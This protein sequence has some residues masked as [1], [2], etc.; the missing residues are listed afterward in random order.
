[1]AQADA[2]IDRRA[3][4]QLAQETLLSQWRTY[5]AQRVIYPERSRQLGEGG[6]VKLKLVFGPS[7]SLQDWGILK[8]DRPIP[9]RLERAVLQAMQMLPDSLIKPNLAPG[10][11]ND[12][13]ILMTLLFDPVAEQVTPSL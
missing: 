1:M 12:P 13:E 11:F 4:T 2:A 3:S 7:G 5:L 10:S 9:V 8:N 6:A